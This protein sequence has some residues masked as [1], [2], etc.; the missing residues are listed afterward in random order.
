MS[1]KREE[2]IKFLESRGVRGEAVAAL[3]DDLEPCFR[4]VVAEKF[5]FG[6]RPDRAAAG[7]AITQWC[8]SRPVDRLA[9]LPAGTLFS[10]QEGQSEQDYRRQLVYPCFVTLVG[11]LPRVSRWLRFR[12]DAKKSLR[13]CLLDDL[14]KS[15]AAGLR[16]GIDRCLDGARD[17]D[18]DNYAG[19][20]ARYRVYADVA[21]L[22][23]WG[24]L[25]DRLKENF[26]NVLSDQVSLVLAGRTD[27]A[28]RRSPLV[29]RM[30]SY[31]VIGPRANPDIWLHLEA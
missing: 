6:N 14:D 12:H 7:Q 28:A 31:P 27:V 24:Y 25:I 21:L 9:F 5:V 1:D 17:F 23:S 26:E 4:Q 29:R 2:L 8:A 10:K 20:N 16:P 11:R 22:T 19:R 3:M 30:G 13:A 15:L 18:I